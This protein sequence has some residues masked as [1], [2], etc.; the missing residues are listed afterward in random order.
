V[1]DPNTNEWGVYQAREFSYLFDYIDANV[2]RFIYRMF[3]TA[4]FVPLSG[5]LSS[6]LLTL[7]FF[8]GVSRTTENLDPLT[9]A[10]LF[11]CMATSF[12]FVSTMVVFYRSGKPLLSAVVL[13]LLFQ[14]KSA[15]R[16]QQV[17]QRR[18][19][20]VTRDAVF[21]CALG[22]AGGLLDRQG[23]I[24]TLGGS[25]IVALHVFWTGRL[26]DVLLG[27]VAATG[28][29]V[30]YNYLLGPLII[31]G[32]NGY[33]P[34]FSYQRIPLPDASTLVVYAILGAKMLVE[35][36]ALLASGSFALGALLIGLLIAVFLLSGGVTSRR[37]WSLSE[38]QVRLAFQPDRRIVAY[39][40]LG[41][42][43]QVVMFALM[44]ARH[45]YVYAYLDHRYWY[46]TLPFVMTVLFGVVQAFDAV[47]PR[48][49]AAIMPAIRGLLV[50]M[51][52][53]N[54][55][56]MP[57]R[58][59]VMETGKWFK[60]VSEQSAALERSLDSGKPDASLDVDYRRFFDVHSDWSSD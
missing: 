14:V 52:V 56:F 48:R 4:L 54:L 45:P 47:I 10:L 55:A 17:S 39:Y 11:G 31:H 28:I 40:A 8:R 34:N 46:Y 3:D 41:F 12:V 20:L 38:A 9:A 19:G 7:V 16:R 13:A 18:T 32:L 5:V 29:L 27:L 23:F 58:R 49:T 59:H 30:A 26:K 42:G 2:Y 15:D 53:G 21:A 50:M 37:W 35:N 6:V 44:I 57:L 43:I 36:V 33:W 1:F 24:Y 60:G 25:V 22:V 51:I